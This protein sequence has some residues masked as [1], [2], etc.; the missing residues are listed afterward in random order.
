MILLQKPTDW[1]SIQAEMKT[2]NLFIRQLN[3]FEKE[4]IPDEVIEEVEK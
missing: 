3:Q 1:K 4:K 2:P